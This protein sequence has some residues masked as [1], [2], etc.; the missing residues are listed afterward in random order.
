MTCEV[1]LGD[2]DLERLPR[3]EGNLGA[4]AVKFQPL[5]V[6]DKEITL[7]PRKRHHTLN[8]EFRQ[9]DEE[10][11][12]TDFLDQGLEGGAL[13]GMGMPVKIFE[14]LEFDKEIAERSQS[15]RCVQIASLVK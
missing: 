8:N 5:R 15:H 7:Q 11:R 6:K 2:L 3:T 10:T 9:L 13:R 14:L 12:G 1:N 4:L